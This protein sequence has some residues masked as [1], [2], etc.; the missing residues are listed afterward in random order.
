MI[1]SSFFNLQQRLP[2]LPSVDDL[3]AE[4]QEI[5]KL[6]QA[7]LKT[8]IF[9]EHKNSFKKMLHQFDK[10]R[11]QTPKYLLVWSYIIEKVNSSRK[12]SDTLTIISIYFP[13]FQRELKLALT[14]RNKQITL[15]I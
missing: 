14:T 2:A 15:D 13:V 8:S 4:S 3:I 6:N 5:N 11:S 1:N 12:A 9:C 7:C 10:I